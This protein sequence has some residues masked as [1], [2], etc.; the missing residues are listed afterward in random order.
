[1]QVEPIKPVL[2][3]LG[4]VLLKLRC[5]EAL[6]NFAFNLNFRRYNAA[7]AL[8]AALSAL[9]D[10]S[11]GDEAAD[12]PDYLDDGDDDDGDGEE[13]DELL[14]ELAALNSDN[15][16]VRRR[17]GGHVRED[18][19]EEVA[20]PPPAENAAEN[21]VALREAVKAGHNPQCQSPF[22]L[23]IA[24]SRIVPTGTQV[25]SHHTF[26]QIFECAHD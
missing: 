24:F 17:G 1:V 5:E 13:A 2:K 16:A 8:A 10:Y 3:A 22:H 25:I 7:A 21:A 14:S 12:Y 9:G 23:M 26:K 18:E 6:S 4:T 20:A 19:A 11:A 15:V